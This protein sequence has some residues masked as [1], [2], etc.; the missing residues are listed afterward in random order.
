MRRAGIAAAA[1]LGLLVCAGCGGVGLGGSN[2]AEKA[3]VETMIRS[4][5][6][7]SAKD[8]TGITVAVNSVICVRTDGH[9]ECMVDATYADGTRLAS[10][11]FHVTASCDGDDGACIWRTTA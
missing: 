9:Y 5:F 2:D 11:Q 4:Q 6:S 10:E 3:K 1:A 7:G 8:L